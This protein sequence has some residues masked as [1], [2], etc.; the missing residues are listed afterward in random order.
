MVTSKRRAGELF[1]EIRAL[2][3]LLLLL[4]LVRKDG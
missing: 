2:L 1:N 3:L 4:L